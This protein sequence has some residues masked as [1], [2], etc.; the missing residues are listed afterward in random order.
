M[1]GNII[2]LYTL[3]GI[4]TSLTGSLTTI[5]IKSRANNDKSICDGMKPGTSSRAM[6]LM[7]YIHGKAKSPYIFHV[8]SILDFRDFLELQT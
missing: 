5:L 4:D 2:V 3:T 7:V 8:V 6:L 1:G